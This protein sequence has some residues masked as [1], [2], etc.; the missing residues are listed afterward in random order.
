MMRAIRNRARIK[1]LER[2]LIE[3]VYQLFWEFAL[4]RL[5]LA[6]NRS[7]DKKSRKFKILEQIFIAQLLRNLLQ[8][9]PSEACSAKLEPARRKLLMCAL[10]LSPALV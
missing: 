3:K 4:V 1:K 8:P 5:S 9:A 7:S 6:R 2:I 10:V